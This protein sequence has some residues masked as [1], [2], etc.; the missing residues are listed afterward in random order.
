VKILIEIEDVRAAKAMFKWLKSWEGVTEGNFLNADIKDIG[1]NM[2][3]EILLVDD[4][5]DDGPTVVI[6]SV[7][8]ISDG[9]YPGHDD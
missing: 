8:E 1:I 6:N 7:K 9:F 3:Q 5:V 2:E 4:I